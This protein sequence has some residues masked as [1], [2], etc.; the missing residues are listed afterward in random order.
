MSKKYYF[1]MDGVL[2]DWV[3][4]YN[5]I[6]I[7]PLDVFSALPKN[8]REQLKI[9]LF[10]YDFFYDMEPI[11][12]GMNMLKEKMDKGYDVCILSASGRVNKEEVIR[13]KKDWVE[14]YIGNINAMFVDK[15]EMKSEKMDRSVINNILIDDR[16]K[17]IDAWNAAGG[18][19]ILFKV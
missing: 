15:V 14:K 4:R 18:I 11:I 16:E 12:S 3:A 7:M 9:E 17:A 19:G 8:E 13:A 5:Q 6:N 1:D 2:A 10:N